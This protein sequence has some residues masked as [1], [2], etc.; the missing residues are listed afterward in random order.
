MGGVA[1]RLMRGDTEGAGAEAVGL[2]I[3]QLYKNLDSLGFKSGGEFVAAIE[4]VCVHPLLF[5]IPGCKPLTLKHGTL[6]LTE[7]GTSD[8]P[9]QAK[10]LGATVVLGDQ[11]AS[12]TLGRLRDAIQ[13]LA[14]D[15]TL[16]RLAAEASAPPPPPGVPPPPA[17]PALRRLMARTNG[18]LGGGEGMLSSLPATNEAGKVLE[19]RESVEAALAVMQERDNV[20]ALVDFLQETVRARPAVAYTRVVLHSCFAKYAPPHLLHRLAS[21]MPRSVAL[22]CGSHSLP[23]PFDTIGHRSLHFI[24]H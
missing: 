4:E 21:L 12:V 7:R 22:R 2:A 1:R 5:S 14:R 19:S 17:P 11:D 24:R 9:L 15:G 3:S 13:T 16:E 6:T 10:A 20:R 23:H 18:A 8:T